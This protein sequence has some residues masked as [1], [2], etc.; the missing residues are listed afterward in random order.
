MRECS[1]RG[2]LSQ[3]QRWLIISV[4]LI[5]KC[6]TKYKKSYE[7]DFKKFSVFRVNRLHDQYK[8]EN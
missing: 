6:L 8:N 5:L 4:L 3:N 7:I 2:S 1:I